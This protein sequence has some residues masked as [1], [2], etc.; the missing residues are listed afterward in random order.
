MNW[1]D[2]GSS[3]WSAKTVQQLE[4]MILSDTN[5]KDHSGGAVRSSP[6]A[7]TQFATAML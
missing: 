6:D 2:F 4:E 7:N 1:Q 3:R 5:H